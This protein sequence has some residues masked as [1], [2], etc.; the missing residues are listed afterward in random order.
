M[1]TQYSLKSRPVSDAQGDLTLVL[2]SSGKTGRRVAK[3][4]ISRNVPVRIG[5]RSGEPPFDWNNQSTWAPVLQKVRSVYLTYYP[6]LAVP[7][8]VDAIRAFTDL[9]VQNDVQHLVLLSGRGEEEAQQSERVVQNS[10]IAWTILRASWFFQ[11]FSEGF[12]REL[13]LSGQ[14]AL[15]AGNVEEPF[16]DAED[17]ADVAV[18]AL[19]E[20]GHIE[21]VYELTSPRLL[22]FARAV[23][24]ISEVTGRKVEY[25]QISQEAF[26]SALAAQGVPADAVALI[27]YVFATVLDGRNSHLADGVQRALNRQPRDFS[28]FLREAAA[29]GVWQV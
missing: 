14:V 29:S 23:E 28:D 24:E 10:G 5:S 7:G 26:I 4:L 25:L 18:A 20:A 9:A 22:T 1:S 16:I 2:G 15:P 11:N 27:S 8:A 13:V 17:I 19:T 21:Q 3:R 6:D 12:F